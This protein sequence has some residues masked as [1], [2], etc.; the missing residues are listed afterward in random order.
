[1]R[2][3]DR[4]EN[5]MSGAP[6]DLVLR[7]RTILADSGRFAGAVAVR[8]GRIVALLGAM[9]AGPAAEMID[10]GGRPVI[11]GLVDTHCRPWASGW[12]RSNNASNTTR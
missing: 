9:E 6:Y 11:P 7:S 4:E 5:D 10:V 2:R 12:H 8:D 1:V 3:Q